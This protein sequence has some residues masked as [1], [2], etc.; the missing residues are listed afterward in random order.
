MSV[1]Q[2]QEGTF[3]RFVREERLFCGILVHLLLQRGRNLQAFLELVSSTLPGSPPLATDRLVEAE[4]YQEF[5]FLRDHWNSLGRDNAAKR[6]LI[7]QLLAR[8]GG[9]ERHVEDD[10][11][12][13]IPRFNE[14][15][16]GP[17]GRRILRDGP[18]IVTGASSAVV[19]ES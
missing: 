13:E 19:S 7:L 11:P 4:V 1:A 8:A 14:F 15:F 10:F 3:Y 9:L 16:M 5:T 2:L 17:R 6:D 18:R 12:E